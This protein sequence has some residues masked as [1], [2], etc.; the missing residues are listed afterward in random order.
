M[1]S[2]SLGSFGFF[3]DPR[4]IH[5]SSSSETISA[6]YPLYTSTVERQSAEGKG[7]FIIDSPSA[8]VAITTALVVFDFDPGI[9]ASPLR[10]EGSTINFICYILPSTKNE[11]NFNTFNF[12]EFLLFYHM[13]LNLSKYNVLTTVLI[14]PSL[15]YI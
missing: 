15:N 6:P 14:W 5:L 4:I 12:K 10:F 11:Q 8:R 3:Q 2:T 7:F 9:F 13:I 1:F